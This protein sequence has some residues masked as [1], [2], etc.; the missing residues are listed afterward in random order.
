MGEDRGE[1]RGLGVNPEL[2]C[3]GRVA[4]L[5]DSAGAKLGKARISAK[6]YPVKALARVRVCRSKTA[7]STM[8]AA[9]IVP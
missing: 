4:A 2:I 1:V 7:R 5:H 8:K 6:R 3:L 9:R